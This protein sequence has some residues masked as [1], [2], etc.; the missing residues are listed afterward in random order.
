M[1]SHDSYYDT[2][3]TEYNEMKNLNMQKKYL[4]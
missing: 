2:K 4:F 3:S 1:A